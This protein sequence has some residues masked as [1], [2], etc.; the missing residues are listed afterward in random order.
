MAKQ[1]DYYIFNRVYEV[2]FCE[3][4]TD[5]TVFIDGEQTRFEHEY[6]NVT[7]EDAVNYSI[8]EAVELALGKLGLDATC[9]I[10][11]NGSPYVDWCLFNAQ[12]YEENEEVIVHENA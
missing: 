7:P 12:P 3:Y 9:I 2:G 11:S 8:S 1:A 5:T 4:A 6:S 10:D